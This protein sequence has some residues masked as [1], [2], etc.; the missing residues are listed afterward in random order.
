L[1]AGDGNDVLHGG[2][3]SDL[4]TGGAGADRFEFSGFNG[5]DTIVDFQQGLD[6]I[7]ILGYGGVL[8][9]FGDLAG[10]ISQAGADTHINLGGVAAGA[11]TIVLDNTQ[12]ASLSSSDFA[13]K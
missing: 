9:K 8:N 7:D 10:H 12:M 6:K 13:F 3:G 2:Q 1:D 4:L 11:G 5:T